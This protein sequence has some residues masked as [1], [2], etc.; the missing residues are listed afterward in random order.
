MDPSEWG[1]RRARRSQGDTGGG[2]GRLKEARDVTE[3]NIPTDLR[4]SHSK[5]YRMTLLDI[6]ILELS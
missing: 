5:L 2:R 6:E 1:L 3:R 4:L